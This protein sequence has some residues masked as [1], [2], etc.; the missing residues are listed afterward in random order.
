[1]TLQ[2]LLSASPAIQFHAFAA[3]AAFGLGIVQ[4]ARR[5][6]DGP[7][8]LSGYVWVG[9][10]LV[11]AASSFWIHGMNQWQGFSVIHLLSI[12]VLA[13]TPIAVMLARRGNIRA[14]K[15][16]MIGLFAGALLIAGFFTFVPGRIMHTVL[17]GG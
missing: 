3:I 7:H 2:P 16:S 17:F 13:F 4:L 11:I 8:R 14:H 12:W 9:L 1:M 15:R 6:G 10:M 5:K